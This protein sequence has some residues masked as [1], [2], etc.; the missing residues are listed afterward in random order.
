MV[1][2]ETT[3]EDASAIDLYRTQGVSSVDDVETLAGRVALALLL[4]G[5]TPGHY[6]VKD[7]AADGVA[8]PVPVPVPSG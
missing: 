6:G 4:A 7:S 5:G 1:G 3:A 8:P 2:V